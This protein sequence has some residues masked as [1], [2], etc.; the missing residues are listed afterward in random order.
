MINRSIVDK[1]NILVTG[2]AGFL[3]SHLCE[4]LVNDAHVICLDNF[5]TS[6]VSNIQHL[7]QHPNFEF[8]NHDITQ[9]FQLVDFPEL[10]Q[11]H[12]GLQGV[13]EIYHLACP[14]SKLHFDDFKIASIL[15]SSIGTKNVL[16]VAVASQAKVL[17]ASSSVLYGPRREGQVYASETD[18]CMLDHL[19][20]FGAYDEGKRFSEAI[21]Y[22]YAD[23]YRL[24]MNIA[25]IFRTY[26]PR[27]KI[28]DGNLIPEMITNA[29]DGTDVALS[30]GEMDKMSLCYVTDIIDGLIKYMHVGTG[31]SVMNLGSDQE[32]LSI[33]VARMIVQIAESSSRIHCASGTSMDTQPPLPDIGRA[34]Q[35]LRW[36]PL[37]QLEQGLTYTIQDA[38]SRRAQSH[39]FG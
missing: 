11:F 22:T 17:Y 34:R 28:H 33:D 19:T 8:I 2:G 21:L 32:H 31:V 7:L 35:Q 20:P 29:F 12:V 9:P 10:E 37:V 24:D 27:M 39:A 30:C 3:G 14:I 4:A 25:R 18:P 23:V 38:R 16:D 26:G 1:K 5:S 15:T 13:Q 36:L 6:H